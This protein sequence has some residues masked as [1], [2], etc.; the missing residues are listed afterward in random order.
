[1]ETHELPLF[2]P[3]ACTPF[4]NGIFF[5]LHWKKPPVIFLVIQARNFERIFITPSLSF[6]TFKTHPR[7]HIVFLPDDV[8]LSVSTPPNSS[9]PSSYELPCLHPWGMEIASRLRVSQFYFLL[10]NPLDCKSPKS[11]ESAYWF[12]FLQHC[13]SHIDDSQMTLKLK[14]HRCF[15]HGS[16]TWSKCLPRDYK[17]FS[18]KILWLYD[19]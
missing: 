18:W 2:M 16:Q 3:A 7:T 9:P 10:Q 6:N 5:Y 17:L 19:M 14:H 15:E 1:M 4:P 11:Q 8:S 13:I 12:V